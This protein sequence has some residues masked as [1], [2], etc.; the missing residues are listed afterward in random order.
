MDGFEGFQACLN[1]NLMVDMIRRILKEKFD[2]I[3]E[4]ITD[5]D[6][7][8]EALNDA[9]GYLKDC[10]IFVPDFRHRIYNSLGGSCV[11]IIEN[12]IYVRL[13]CYL[14]RSLTDWFVMH[15]L[16]HVLVAY[17]E[18]CNNPKFSAEFGEPQPDD[19]D[20]QQWK[21]AFRPCFVQTGSH[22]IMP[23]MEVRGEVCGIDS[24]HVY[25]K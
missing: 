24:V 8:Q 15:E 13:G 16:A 23:A 11:E 18:P 10:G 21:S 5:T 14:T 7:T 22:P 17:H 19:Y 4:R 9:L 6:T 3:V 25:A 1:V 2:D 20:G 12:G